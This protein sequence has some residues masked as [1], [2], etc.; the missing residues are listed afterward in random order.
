MHPGWLIKSEVVRAAAD[1]PIGPFRFEEV[2]LP[3]RG[4]QYWDGVATHNPHIKKIGDT[5]VLY[6]MGTTHPFPEKWDDSEKVV[7]ARANKRIG[8]ATS[9]SIFGPWERSDNPILTARP[10]FFDSFLVSD[11]AP[12]IRKDGNVL[13]LYKSRSYVVNEEC[14]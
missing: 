3:A 6:Y 14:T 9:K 12:C 1:T 4:A 7:A 13:M 5:Y 10:Q 11:P 2:V 8:I